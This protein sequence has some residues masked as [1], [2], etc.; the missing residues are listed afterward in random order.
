MTTPNY[1]EENNRRKK[2]LE[3]EEA[4]LKKDVIGQGADSA[5]TRQNL[6]SDMESAIDGDDR[7]NE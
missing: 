2:A 5:S 7:G 1:I 4:F 6:Q 3:E